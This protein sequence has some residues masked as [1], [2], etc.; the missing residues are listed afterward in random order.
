MHLNS[1]H[2]FNCD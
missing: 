1:I 2:Y